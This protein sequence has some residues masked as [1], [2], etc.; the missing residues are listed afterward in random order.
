MLKKILSFKIFAISIIAFLPIVIIISIVIAVAGISM[1]YEKI[2]QDSAEARESNIVVN[3]QIYASRYRTLLNKYLKTKGYVSLER[4][5]FY[6][7]RKNNVLDITTLSDEEWATAYLDNLNETKK[8]MIPIKTVCF[9]LK[10]D[11]TLP[12]YT[13]ET[14]FNDDGLLIEKLDLCNVDGEDI[15]TSND[16]SE[17]YD[18]LP[19][20]FPLKE[21]YTVTSMVFENRNVDFGLSEK[22]QE[23]VNHHSG[24]DFSV[25]IGTKFYS[26]CSGSISNIVY[27]QYNDLPFSNSKNQIGNYVEVKC[28]NGLTVSYKHIKASS[29]PVSLKKGSEV[30]I[31]DFLGLTSTTGRSTGPHLHL[32]L[33]N[34][35]GKRLDALQFIDFA[36]LNGNNF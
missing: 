26:V 21:D 29:V 14:D 4:L 3:N 16:Y 20:I 32:E 1:G 34:S 15:T 24:W 19:Y 9:D 6:L 31:D 17:G 5:V 2:Y 25:P 27:T 10:A 12:D 18:D 28:D 30:K 13:I 8:R 11:E 22:E 35:D 7:Q 33:Y 23:S 36:N